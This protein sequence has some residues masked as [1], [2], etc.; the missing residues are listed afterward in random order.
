M[1]V[2]QAARE[3]ARAAAALPTAAHVCLGVFVGGAVWF[4]CVGPTWGLAFNAGCILG[5]VFVH[6]VAVVPLHRFRRTARVMPGWLEDAVDEAIHVN[7]CACGAGPGEPCREPDGT[8]FPAL[9]VHT[10]RGAAN[11][12]LSLPADS[13][14]H[15]AGESVH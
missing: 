6:F 5:A 14:S 15:A 11:V 10:G 9:H 8:P 4:F 12:V 7:P 13:P 2:R 3:L 1:T